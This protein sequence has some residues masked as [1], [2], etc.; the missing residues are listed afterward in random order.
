[1]NS[2]DVEIW[3]SQNDRTEI[4]LENIYQSKMDKATHIKL[5][6]DLNSIYTVI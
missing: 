3:L 5:L 1:M 2:F 6:Q 4:P